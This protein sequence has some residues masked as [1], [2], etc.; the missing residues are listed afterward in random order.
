MMMILMILIMLSVMMMIPR[1]TQQ[2]YS[3]KE[4]YDCRC[5]PD[6]S[7]GDSVLLPTIQFSF[8]LADI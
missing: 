7:R 5:A 1:S 2:M 3:P 6:L 4:V 8:G